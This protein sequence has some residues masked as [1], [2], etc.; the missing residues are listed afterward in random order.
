MVRE[1]VDRIA[2]GDNTAIA[3]ASTAFAAS[4]TDQRGAFL[5]QLASAAGESPTCLDV[6]LRIVDE[7]GLDRPAI[8][9]VLV[10]ND[11]ADD[12]HQD[13]LIAI[14]QGIHKFR[15][16]AAFTT[17]LHS[18]ARFVAIDHLRRRKE[19][20]QLGDDDHLPTAATKLSSLIASRSD[21]AA[22]VNAL[23]EIYRQPVILRDVEQHTYADIAATLEIE[24]NTVKSRISRGRALV[25]SMLSEGL[26]ESPRPTS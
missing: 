7:H 22:A 17:W 11:Q 13:V 3:Q 10:D 5:N 16:D 24:L 25:A 20:Q 14:A 9:R 18:V 4:D 8:R 23:P 26:V 15:G 12:A 19:T 2:A 6:L 1:W 21:L